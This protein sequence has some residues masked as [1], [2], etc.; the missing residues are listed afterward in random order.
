VFDQ[1]IE[2]DRS[3]QVVEADVEAAAGADQVLDLGIG[4]GAR[5]L[6]VK[7]HQHDLRDRQAEQAGKLAGDHLGDQRLRA[8][9]GAAE[10]HHVHAVVVGLD[11]R[12]Q[13]TAFAQR[14]DIAGR[15]D[16]PHDGCSSARGGSDQSI[17]ALP[18][19]AR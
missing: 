9:P 14:G 6:G 16:R 2:I 3:G 8:L 17:G 7:F 15:G 11:H 13:R 19:R 18:L 5:Q 10:L 12:R 4:L 1:R